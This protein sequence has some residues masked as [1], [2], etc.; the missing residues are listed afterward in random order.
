MP[1]D[2][3][4]R[5]VELE[6]ELK[7]SKERVGELRDEVDELR[8]KNRRMREHVEDC[9]SLI[10]GWCEAFGMEMIDGNRW[11]WK[12]FWEEYDRNI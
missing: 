7:R 11:T 8:D 4:Q 12:S 2:K 10:E 3:N 1:N 9:D 6:E 5:I